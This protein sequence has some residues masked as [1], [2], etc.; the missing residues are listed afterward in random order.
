MS[1]GLHR[2][3]LLCLILSLVVFAACVEFSD[4]APA[5]QPS[6]S[7]HVAPLAAPPERTAPLIPGGTLRLAMRAPRTLNPLLN[8]DATVARVLQLMFEPLIALDDELRPVPH[9]ANLEFAFN[10]ASVVVIIRE[11]ALWSDGVPVTSDDLLFSLETLQN[12]PKEAVYRRF[13]E[14]VTHFERLGECSVRVYFGTISGG[15]AYMF[16][17]PVIPRHHFSDEPNSLAPVSNGP[18]RFDSYNP[19]ESLRLVRNNNTFRRLP[20]IFEVYALITPDAETDRHAFDRGLVDIYLA[21]VPDWARHHSVKPVHHAEFL[22]MHYDFIGFNHARELPARLAFRQA[23]AYTLDAE[24]LISDI[25]LTHAMPARA[26]VHPA[27]WLYEPDV[28][29]FGYN[30]EMAMALAAQ[31]RMGGLPTDEDGEKIPLTVLVSRENTEGQRIAQLLVRQL[32]L[33]GLPA[34]LVSLPLD[35]YAAAL[36]DGDFDLF[37]GGYNLCFQ[38]DLRFAFHSESPNN[39]LSYSDPE[40]DRLLEAAAVAGTDSQLSRMLSDIQVHMGRQLPVI[41]LAFRHSAVVADRG[42]AGELRPMPG[43]IFAN[44]EEW[45]VVR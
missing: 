9:L 20:N 22:A 36:L 1:I 38:P 7:P 29:V 35:E 32:N 10:G 21:A 26:A 25:F 31:V 37:V 33:I 40:L 18:F 12:A 13:I 34:E 43:N 28:P 6:P 15:S 17:F 8:E 3:V 4:E 27:S 16:A 42:V 39:I 11:D 5:A 2:I 24:G 14:N 45:F 19:A 30:I 44:V 41:S 23:V